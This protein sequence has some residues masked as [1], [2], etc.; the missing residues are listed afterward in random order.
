MA[1]LTLKPAAALTLLS[2]PLLQLLQLPVSPPQVLPLPAPTATAAD[3]HNQ[4]AWLL[5]LLGPSTCDPITPRTL[6]TE[7]AGVHFICNMTDARYLHYLLLLQALNP[8]CLLG[9]PY[10]PPPSTAATADGSANADA[11]DRGA[12]R[13]FHYLLLLLLLLDP[14]PSRC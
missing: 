10:P 6:L 11:A 13:A 7:P 1:S 4:H 8:S 14:D 2:L 3:R 5:L 12:A 9:T